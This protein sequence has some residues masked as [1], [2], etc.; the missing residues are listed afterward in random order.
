MGYQGVAN[1]FSQISRIYDKFL[2]FA[3]MGQVHRWQ[4]ELI[5]E[6]N[7]DGNWL[8][9]GTGTGEVLRKIP[10][11]N[12]CV[13]IDP[14]MGMLSV[15]KAKCPQCFFVQ[16]LGEN[17]PFG[18]GVF[19]NI[20]LSLVFRHLQDKEAFVREAHRVLKEGGKVGL[21]DI[22]RFK[23]TGALLFLMRTL[24]KPLGLIIFGKEKWDFFVHSVEESYTLDEVLKMF[25]EAGFEESY[26]G[27]RFLGIVHIVVVSKTA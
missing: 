4:R 27:R 19:K 13:G 2:N 23:G 25:R 1:I 26:S 16:A 12:I 8:D 20:T 18:E 10:Q 14:A 5:A 24:F 15:A 21:I 6:M 22:G 11:K 7:P 17:L 9:V 3:T